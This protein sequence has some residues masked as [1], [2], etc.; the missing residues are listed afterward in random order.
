MKTEII[1][2][3]L[4]LFFISCSSKT[5]TINSQEE[6]IL[7]KN[8]E[9]DCLKKGEGIYPLEIYY[10]GIGLNQSRS[11]IRTI[12]EVNADSVFIKRNCEV[13]FAFKSDETEFLKILENFK[14]K[15]FEGDKH[16]AHLLTR[17][18]GSWIIQSKYS[19]KKLQILNFHL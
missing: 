2:V 8:I 17:D 15:D 11:S 12:I 7:E 1:N 18:G 13:L 4:L 3:I 9:K 14:E 16:Y 6:I 19:K 10:V 5:E